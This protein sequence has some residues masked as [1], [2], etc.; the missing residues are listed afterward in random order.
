MRPEVNIGIDAG[1]TNESD[2]RAGVADETVEILMHA[3]VRAA[4]GPPRTHETPAATSPITFAPAVHLP[5]IQDAC[6]CLIATA[7]ASRL[8]L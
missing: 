7:N 1:S 6:A 2:R 3:F 5:A 4:I 8:P